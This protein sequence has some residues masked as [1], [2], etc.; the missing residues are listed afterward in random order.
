[1]LFSSEKISFL[2][3]LFY[4]FRLVSKIKGFFEVNLNLIFL[5]E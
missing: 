2:G 1:M 5:G 4:S 3:V